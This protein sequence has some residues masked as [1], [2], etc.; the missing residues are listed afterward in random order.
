MRLSPACVA[1]V[2]SIVAPAARAD[3][4]LPSPG[5]TPQRGGSVCGLDG[6]EVAR[7]IRCAG[8]HCTVR[9]WLLDRALQRSR[10]LAACARIVPSLV[11]G[12]PNGFK[13]YAIRPGSL[14][15]RL[16]VQ[17]GDTIQRV[18]GLELIAPE[19]PLEIYTR[20]RAARE[21][22]V[23]LERRGRPRRLFYTIR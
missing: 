6:A 17:N 7:A 15:A 4:S 18:N 9:R 21:L 11:D 2:L 22:V 14:L 13:L 5:P 20:V 1:L 3:A 12:R 16:Q 19:R 23:D 10:E 8:D